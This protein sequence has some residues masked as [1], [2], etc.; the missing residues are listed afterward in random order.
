VGDEAAW[1]ALVE[2]YGGNPLALH[3]VGE[4]ISSVFDG[5]I[6]AFLAQ[7]IAVFGGIRHLLDEQ[8]ARLS[9]LEQAVLAWLA[10][11]R[12]PIGLRE[13]AADLGL[14]VTRAQVVEVVEALRRRS[15]LEPGGRGVF[16]LQPVV[17]EYMTARL[18]AQGSREVLAGEPALL[19]SHALVKA[20]SK[21]YVRRSQEQLIVQPLLE[22]LG[23]SAGSAAAAE[24]RLLA[25]LDGWRGRGM[26]STCCGCYGVTFAD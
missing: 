8:V 26:W 12:E 24:R 15:L 5:E 22:Q 23:A 25:L 18:L 7:E 10:V 19:V 20:Q 1:R 2:R 17:L 11:E 9:A 6:A 16:T 14:G 3:V 4:T 21:D 13:L